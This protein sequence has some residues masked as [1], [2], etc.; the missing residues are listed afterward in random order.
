MKC[1][2]LVLQRLEM[3]YQMNLKDVIR[4][5]EGELTSQGLNF[6]TLYLALIEANIDVLAV[7]SLSLH[8]PCPYVAYYR[9]HN[10][11]HY[12]LV[13]SISKQVC[14]YDPEF[15]EIHLSKW[16]FYLKWSK[17]ALLFTTK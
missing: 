9:Y 2:I 1:A 14:L 17:T 7:H 3:K 12:V 10:S 4:K 8:L 15:G 16:Q 11:G 6:Y 5:C 13:E